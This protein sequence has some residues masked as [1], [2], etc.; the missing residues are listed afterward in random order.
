MASVNCTPSSMVLTNLL[1]R[2][3]KWVKAMNTTDDQFFQIHAQPQKPKVLWLGCSDSR[4]PESV[5]TNSIPG[6][7]FV[8]RNIANQFHLDDDNSVSVLTYAVE[9]LEVEHVIVVGHTN[10]GGVHEA[11][12]A[13]QAPQKSK[14]DS[15]LRRWLAP[16][17]ELARKTDGDLT[18][19]VEANVREQVENIL[20]SE[21][22]KHEWK[23]RDVRVHGWVYQ[24]ETG[25]LRDLGIS[26][27]D[28]IS[29][30]P[31]IVQPAVLVPGFAPIGTNGFE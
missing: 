5:I 3:E 16:L 15:A 2:N 8:Q 23:R 11:R 25:E 20:K 19:L 12:E 1:N 9:H 13:A 21:A 27:F 31:F 30:P 10:C 29:T 7:I 24:L 18:A 26:A 22:I 4:V 6:D 17:T 28:S 14:L